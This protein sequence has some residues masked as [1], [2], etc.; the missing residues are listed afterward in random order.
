M[1]CPKCSQ[2][3][4][5]EDLR[6]CPR[7]GFPLLA[8]Q[9]L[10]LREEA[11]GGDARLREEGTLPAQKEIVTGALL[12]FA[13]SIV[14]VLWGFMGTRGPV[15][16][17][18]PQSYFIMGGTLAFLLTLFHPLLRW[19]EGLT[20]AG[21]PA[22]IS[23]RRD[24]INLGAILMFVGALKATVLSSLMPLGPE[25]GVTTLLFMAGML[26]LVLLL[27]PILRAARG[28]FFGGRVAADS[29]DDPA[30]ARLEG[31]EQAA[32]LPPAQSMPAGGFVPARADTA[33]LAAP[34]SVTEE[35]TRKLGL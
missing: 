16:V 30:T 8:V 9:E 17:L 11:R 28:L 25:R 29:A 21:E 13:G 4:P 14:A 3:Q 5:A 20:S 24:G 10:I 26:L 15:E 12:M 27:R 2:T 33:E 31:R 1:F 7:C 32:A 19:L 18:L 23:R 6:F 34:P 35:T 22:D